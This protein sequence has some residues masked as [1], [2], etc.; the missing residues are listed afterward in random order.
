M[1]RHPSPRTLVS[2]LVL[3]V[4]AALVAYGA[5]QASPAAAERR[6]AAFIQEWSDRFR[7]LQELP[8]IERLPVFTRTFPNGEW[9]AAICEHACCSG[10]GFNATVVYDSEGVVRVNRTH[11]YCGME[12]L[13]SEMGDLPA[14]SLVEFYRELDAIYGVR[15][16]WYAGRTPREPHAR[17]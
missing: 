13:M 10:R 4:C 6:K 5:Y 15:L 17:K 8:S 16:E 3:L 11:C 7:I 1:R 14:E 2:T 9:V 12:A